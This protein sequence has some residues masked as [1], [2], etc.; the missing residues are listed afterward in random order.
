MVVVMVSLSSSLW[1][2]WCCHCCP[3]CP[4]PHPP[5]CC[6]HHRVN[7]GWWWCHCHYHLVVIPPRTYSIHIKKIKSK[8][9]K[10]M[11]YYLLVG[12]VQSVG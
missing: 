2:W 3:P 12:L 6:H 5:H 1:R 8:L 11:T 10:V 7:A 9:K 4:H